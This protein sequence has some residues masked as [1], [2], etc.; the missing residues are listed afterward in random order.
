MKHF[1][2]VIVLALLI[3][4][5]AQGDD[6]GKKSAQKPKRQVIDLDKLN[7]EG[8]VPHPSTLF[9]RERSADFLYELFPIERELGEDWLL[10][11][12]KSDFDSQTVELI[13]G[14]ER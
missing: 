12:I 14:K 2:W 11:V 8:K 6:A 4:A 5:P 9:I 13:D 1:G 10:P 3:G 7:I